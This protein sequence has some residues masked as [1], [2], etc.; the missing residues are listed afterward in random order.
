MITQIIK[1]F[2]YK[3]ENCVIWRQKSWSLSNFFKHSSHFNNLYACFKHSS[4]EI[5]LNQLFWSKKGIL[6]SFVIQS[7]PLYST[8]L[9]P[10]NKIPFLSVAYFTYCCNKETTYSRLIVGHRKQ[11]LL[12]QRPIF[13]FFLFVFTL[14]VNLWRNV[15]NV[16][17][18]LL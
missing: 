6:T 17:L 4:N 15:K 11:L 18:L 13:S 9:E 5:A 2:I 8:E 7:I 1:A 14:S 3:V 12:K 16:L 10:A